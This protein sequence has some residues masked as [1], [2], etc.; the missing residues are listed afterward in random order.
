[1]NNFIRYTLLLAAFAVNTGYAQLQFNINSSNNYLGVRDYSGFTSNNAYVLKFTYNGT[2]LNVPNWRVAARLRGP[3]RSANSN[4]VFPAD[5]IALKFSSISGNQP[6]LPTA[7]NI[8]IPPFVNLAHPSAETWL[9]PRSNEPL[10]F[11][12][13]YAGYYDFQ[14][15]FDLV[16]QPG[17][18][19][20]E[21]TNKDNIYTQQIYFMPIDF[22]AYD[23]QGREI[24]KVE[25]R[26]QI[27]VFPLQ[28]AP[29]SE[30]NYSFKIL[31]NAQNALLEYKTIT[32]YKRGAS[33]NY[34]R[35]LA[36]SSNTAY[37]LSVRSVSPTLVAST[38]ETLPID[39]VRLEVTPDDGQL[40]STQDI[41]LQQTAQVIVRGK[42]TNNNY[43]YFNMRYHS[44]SMQPQLLEA[45][46]L[47]YSTVLEFEITPQ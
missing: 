17:A 6:N 4:Q 32:D 19:L 24:G 2:S 3:I 43:E 46:P 45:K 12:S 16:I 39:I 36:I 14:I 27:D 10:F 35:A 29:P 18:Y 42:T 20:S 47:L 28:G 41:P 34:P 9:V 13:S 7:G 15:H 26:Y 23:G 1:M 44:K 25:H 37:Q 11:Q 31:G 22:I 38:G 5:K 30:N 8:P 40:V 33:V 21:L